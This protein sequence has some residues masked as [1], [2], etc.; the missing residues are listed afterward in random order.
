MDHKTYRS[1]VTES[2]PSASIFILY[3]PASSCETTKRMCATKL[4]RTFFEVWWEIYLAAWDPQD[5]G[6]LLGMVDVDESDLATDVLIRDRVEQL[7]AIGAAD[8]RPG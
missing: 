4:R 2:R 1:T 6:R 5:H 3:L 7:E 8:V